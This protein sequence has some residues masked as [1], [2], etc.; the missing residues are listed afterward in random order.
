M[1][2][3]ITTIVLS[4]FILL[5]LTS[6]VWGFESNANKLNPSN[7]KDT[8]LREYT[9]ENAAKPLGQGGY[10]GGHDTI[11]NEAAILKKGVHS[12]A[13][14]GKFE[15]FIDKALPNLRTGAHDEDSKKWGAWYIGGEKP[16]GPN[17]DGD[18]TKHFFDR[19]TGKGWYGSDSAATQAKNYMFR[20][21][22]VLGC[23][24]LCALPM[25]EQKKVFDY[26][27]RIGHLIADMAVPEHHSHNFHGAKSWNGWVEDYSP[28]NWN[29]IVNCSIC[30]AVW[31]G[32]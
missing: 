16:I 30:A 22:N 15:E 21:Y 13:D 12:G 20:M 32:I 31:E 4:L 5:F 7:E 17:G 19:A 2:K 28:N 18:Y 27:G 24:E 25:H 23:K 9:P 8:R 26:I 29:D 11:M 6:S 10:H 14:K 1:L 3:K